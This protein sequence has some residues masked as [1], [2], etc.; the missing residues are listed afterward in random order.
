M[1]DHKFCFIICTD[2]ERF[3]RECEFYVSYL[4]IPEG[5]EAEIMPVHEA[6]GM[7]AGYN[8]AMAATD[9]K[10]KIYIHQDTFI[11]NPNF[12]EDL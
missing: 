12:M 1:N 9:A 11:L 7:A 4:R 5:Y 2:S 10:Y 3:Y 6:S 8:S